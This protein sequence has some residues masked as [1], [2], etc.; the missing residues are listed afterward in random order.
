M[1]KDEIREWLCDWLS[2]HLGISPEEVEGDRTLASYGLDADD[3]SR[4]QHDVEEALEE[5]VEAGA[6][7]L[8]ST[9]QS[10]SKY[11]W[12]LLGNDDD[13]DFDA[14]PRDVDMDEA[15]RDIGMA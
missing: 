8:R 14:T 3:L 11:L 10:L 7:R 13:D 5:R 15:L 1:T 9:V 2:D 12:E 4:L 6:L